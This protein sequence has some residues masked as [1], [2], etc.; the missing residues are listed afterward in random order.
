MRINWINLQNRREME[1][2]L[3]APGENMYTSL[4]RPREEH[5]YSS[6][7]TSIFP[8][9]STEGNFYKDVEGNKIGIIKRQLVFVAIYFSDLCKF[10][11]VL[12]QEPRI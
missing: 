5:A 7:S 4:S 3:A 2:N 12:N 8:F 9:H 11:M 6:T 1:N 10:C